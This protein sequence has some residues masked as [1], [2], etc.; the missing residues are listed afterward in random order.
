MQ[1]KN[2]IKRELYFVYRAV[3]K[4][5][6]VYFNFVYTHNSLS[7]IQ[8]VAVERDQRDLYFVER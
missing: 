5:S 4:Q 2:G 1:V 7:P 3:E 8:S 6:R